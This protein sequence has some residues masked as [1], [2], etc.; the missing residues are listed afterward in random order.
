MS[1]DPIINETQINIVLDTN[2]QGEQPLSF[3]KS[4]LYNKLLQDMNGYSD[5]PYFS[6]AIE[7]PETILKNL[8][9]INQ[10]AFFFKKDDFLRILKET[11]QYKTLAEKMKKKEIEKTELLRRKMKGESVIIDISNILFKMDES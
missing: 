10:V 7:Y 1:V 11:S 8:D 9:Y 6:S 3:T 2:I 5:Y 4:V